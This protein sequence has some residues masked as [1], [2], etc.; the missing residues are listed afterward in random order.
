MRIPS[1]QRA[2]PRNFVAHLRRL[3]R[4][5][6]QDTALI[7]LREYDGRIVGE[8]MGYGAFEQRVRAVAARLQRQ[9]A[10]GDRALLLLDNDEHYAVA[11]FACMFAGLIAVPAF[12]PESQRP[13]HLAR[14][15][16]MAGDARASCV[17][18][19]SDLGRDLG[20]LFDAMPAA[21]R[22]LVDTVDTQE[23][24]AWREHEPAD[25]DI[26]FLQ[27][28][29]GSTAAPKGVMV[30][31]GNLM[32]NERAMEEMLGLASDDVFASWLPL[33]HD[34]GL[35]GGLMQP[36]HRG[37]PLLLMAPRFFLERPLRWLEAIARYRVTV[38]GGPD[39]A[40][41]LC[42]DRIRSSQAEG[43]DLSSWRIAYTGAEPV[44]H[45]TLQAFGQ[46][47][48]AA[49]F[50]M[51]AF[52]P[53][54]GLAEATLFITGGREVRG[55]ACGG[56]DGQAL[57]EGRLV[58]APPG[59]GTTL[60]G[61]GRVAA[62]HAVRIADPASGQALPPDR[63]GEIWACGPS[64]AGG[65]WGNEPAS[66][67]ALAE[68]DGRTWL[69]TGDLGFMHGGQLFVAG[70]IKDVIIVRGHNLYPQDIE[71]AIERE[72]E[73]VRPGR[74]AAFAVA[75]EGG[76]GGEGIGIAAEISRGMQKLARPEALVEAL[77]AVV[78]ALCGEP[79]SVVALLQPGALPKTS[80]GKL[81]RQSARQGVAD[82][83]LGAYAV[84]RQ[85]R[86]VVGE[87]AS[88][89]DGDGGE[90]APGVERELAGIWREVL[91]LDGQARV[92]RDTNFF[93]LGGNSL[94]ATQVAVR[95]G[96]RWGVAMG[97][98]AVFEAPVLGNLAAAIS[99]AI[100]AAASAGMAASPVRGQEPMAVLA[101]RERH[102]PMPLSAAQQRQWF[103]WR[104]DPQGTAYHVCMAL[105][106]DGTVDALC[107][108]HAFEGLVR[109]H[110]SLRTVF[111]PG[112]D[113]QGLQKVLE[114]ADFTLQRLDL[115]ALPRPAQEV[116]AAVRELEHRPF[117]LTQAPPLR[118]ALIRE[119]EG[120]HTLAVV[121]HHIISDGTSMQIL[122]DELGMRYS[123]LAAGAE[124]GIAAQRLQYADYAAWQRSWLQGQGLAAHERERQLAYWIGELGEEVDA[125]VLPTDHAHQ[126][127][128]AYRAA[129]RYFELPAPL[130]AAVRQKAA[131]SGTTVFML[132][133][134]ALQV[135][136]HRYG[137]QED[138][139][140]GVPI[141]NRHRP[142]TAAVVGFFVNTQVLRVRLG[143]RTTLADALARTRRAALDAQA[144]QD[145]P[146]E[147]LVD[148]LRP[149]RV[150]GATPLF[151]VLFN[152]LREDFR[153]IE[154]STGWR[155]SRLPVDA[156]MAQFD[157]AVEA[158][159]ISDG[160]IRMRLTHARELF[161]ESTM[162]SFSEHYLA[163]LDALLAQPGLAIGDIALPY[164]GSPQA[165]A[166][167]PP[168]D[169]G[170]PGPTLHGMFE[171]QA[172]ARPH[173]IAV[174]SGGTALSYAQLNDSANRLAHRLL[175]MGLGPEARVGV[176]LQRSER[177]PVALLAILKAGATYV[178]LDPAYPAQRLSFIAADA[179]IALLLTESAV[180]A[181][182][183]LDERLIALALDM[184][185]A[186]P[187][188]EHAGNPQRPVHADQLAY[189]IYTSGSTGRPKGAQ[190]SHRNVTRLLETASPLFGFGS[191]D[192]WTLF[193]SYAFD[194]SVW[195]IFGPLCTGG[196]LV[197]VSHLTS[198]SPTDMLALLR[199]QGV[200][201]L[202]Q[203][204]SAFRQLVHAVG[205]HGSEGLALREVVFGGEALELESL[206]PWFAHFGDGGPRL[207][208]MFGITETTVHVSFR[209]IT[210]ADLGARG[211]SPIGL[212]LP[213]LAVHVLDAE[214]NPVPA[215]MPGELY[216]EGEG[217]ARGYLRRG[218]LTSERFVA[219][220]FGASGSRMYRTGDRGR[221]R[222]DGQ[223]EYLGRGDQ[224]VKVRGFRIELG[225]IDAQ[226]LALEQVRDAATVAI[227]GSQLAS[228]VVLREGAGGEGAAGEGAHLQ[229]AQIRQALAQRLPDY[230][231][232]AAVM[233]VDALPLTS[234]GKL[235]RRAL[236]APEG[237][238]SQAYEEPQ[239]R[240]AQA[241]AA[242]WAEVL[243]VERVGARDNFF[244]LG[245]HSLQLLRV[246]HLIEERLGPVA[247]VVELFRYPTVAG[248]A[249]HIE[250]G[251]GTGV[252]TANG[253]AQEEQRVQRQLAALQRRRQAAMNREES[254]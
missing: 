4:E 88:D 239:G 211:P 103:L 41:R 145:L 158:R 98:G 219:N 253:A 233:R 127:K 223:L 68:Q 194:F 247:S 220:P 157:L 149:E 196:R 179:G 15:A 249:A 74:V 20:A 106:I 82:G 169:R 73:A 122:A 64:I 251:A 110:E 44:R 89:G 140:V 234:N 230:M 148:V 120:L 39:F 186:Q 133:L 183:A 40:F 206:R 185:Q 170:L 115:R 86:F 78:S 248:L 52:Q 212:A 34:M 197:V 238:A 180:L 146:F 139:R 109:Q 54:Y 155:V 181:S 26:A 97:A 57:T 65:Y 128:A 188:A 174:V 250:Q 205:L 150:V 173:A 242:I 22:I 138:V 33:Y 237:A 23:A 161:E 182:Q 76:E 1:T 229:M 221:R 18:T 67:K 136:L 215:G 204:P 38:T 75:G 28:T 129:N 193:H 70:R 241:L 200:T 119:A 252:A 213:D 81:Q 12:A 171:R 201:V 187:E 177:I 79:V 58:Q 254:I 228:Y 208:N 143:G 178:P 56:F 166:P 27:Y 19:T 30:S 114:Q 101:P 167:L 71:R 226:L 163:V 245:G 144:N 69:R 153:A 42:L 121:M 126:D 36:I 50:D 45:D 246:H 175:A 84:W 61:C 35:I 244:D 189:L 135:L 32:A 77:G 154:S 90:P 83:S 235:D 66:R 142:G 16:G 192:V 9:C 11:F 118:A 60:V 216:V 29:S 184:D 10:E 207:V 7:P 24:L 112:Q 172:A 62:G 240:A 104:L 31:H 222:A 102:A 125:I 123:A 105:R 168:L 151:Q 53:C 132:L 217:L 37:A 6:P 46:R 236:P 99:A 17:L 195:E 48:G 14:L 8:A 156:A 93:V 130:A 224:Q 199:E 162:A 92:G 210:T 137:G 232:P 87:G 141:A 2:Y 243:K 152:C 13:Q 117:D 214:L 25:T 147:Q 3:A 95:I 5:R 227:G 198:R 225:E 165:L 164:A 159:D 190:L 176:A 94:T 47:F 21:A 43:L 51:A 55:L 80:S 85:G 63:I 203:T 96:E 108:Q 191:G 116:M 124:P 134:S 72:V 131:A 218:A 100:S 111:E 107:L 160:S 49:G 202:N 231:V 59:G 209:P 113:N 91:R